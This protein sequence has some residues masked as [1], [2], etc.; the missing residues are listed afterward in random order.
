MWSENNWLVHLPYW[1]SICTIY[2]MQY[3]KNILQRLLPGLLIV[4]LTVGLVSLCKGQGIYDM[5]WTE[6]KK[7]II[8][9]YNCDGLLCGKIVYVSVDDPEEQNVKGTQILR[10]FKKVKADVWKKGR[11]Y[12]PRR[13]KKFKGKIKLRG[14]ELKLRGYVGIS[15]FGKTQTWKRVRHNPMK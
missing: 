9:V 4:L 15:L 2:H 6:D 11:I 13:D 12:D 8:Q 10:D 5:W 7:S 14:D 3:Y 1:A